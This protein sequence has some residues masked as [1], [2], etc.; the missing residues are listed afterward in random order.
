MI[1]VRWMGKK[2]E[3][4]SMCW[5]G[6][7]YIIDRN[8]DKEYKTAHY[9][10][11]CKCGE[12][13]IIDVRKIKDNIKCQHNLKCKVC[14]RFAK[15][16]CHFYPKMQLCNRHYTQLCRHGYFLDN[17]IKD[18]I[19]RDDWSNEEIETL[20]ELYSKN[21]KISDIAKQLGRT[22][23]AV[24]SKAQH[25]GI[26]SNI[27]KPNNPNFKAIYQDYDWCY[28]RFINKG[29]S[30]QEM[31]DEAGTTVRTIQKWCSE[32]HRLNDWTFK[33]EKKLN[34]L[35]KQIVMFG[36]L[37]DGHIDKR[38]DQ[39]MYI[40]VHAENQKDYLFWKW[41]ILK[42]ICN[43]EPV[44]YP[45]NN[46]C[47]NGTVYEVQPTYR[48][49]TRTVYDLKPIRNMSRTEIISKLNELGLSLHLL[50]DGY[51]SKSNWQLCLAEYTKDEVNLYID[52]CQNRFGLKAKV[53]KDERYIQFTAD[54]SRLIDS[55]IL[56]NIPNEL[57]IVQQKII[58][59]YICKPAKYVYV[60]DNGSLI[61]LNTFCRNHQL[62]Y[63]KCKRYVDAINANQ[64]SADEL[65]NL[66]EHNYEAV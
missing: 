14:G 47:F 58:N 42:D 63:K 38:E 31:A 19:P 36:R 11:R 35:Q 1:G 62:I 66:K 26:T 4:K 60:E 40:E 8:Y 17:E 45:N 23:G 39:P 24:S 37:G 18:V 5:F 13:G 2:A 21:A 7:Y 57:D 34:D 15:D 3:D 53:L 33:T 9:N 54:S 51:R 22:E 12:N 46:K 61:G 28:E 27:I 6:D 64:I 65:Y 10:Y 49:N 16:D 50:D 25:I 32:K 29:M 56:N 52:I 44:Y 48:L 20:I 59:T 55:I 43:H 30:M 41:S